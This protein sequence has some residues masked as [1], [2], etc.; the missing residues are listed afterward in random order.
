MAQYIARVELHAASYSNYEFLNS[1]MAQQGFVRTLVGV[2]C[3]TYQ[4]PIGTYVLS[5]NIAL[6]EVLNRAVAA[7]STTLK[8]SAVVVAEWREAMWQG[9]TVVQ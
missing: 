1:Q 7:A 5:S 9:L 3:T 6:Q 8:S 2:N 4:L